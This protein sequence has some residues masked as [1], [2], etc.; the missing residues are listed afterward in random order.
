MERKHIA[1]FTPLATGHVYPALGVCSELVRRGHRVTYPTNDRFASR[2]RE[3]GAEAIEFKAP[4][5]RYP[6]K[7][8]QYPSSDE[9]SYWRAF[10]SMYGP[11]VIATAATTVV[12]LEGFYA[13]NP[14][15]LILYEWFSFAGRIISRQLGCPCV[16]LH[17]H[18]A[19]HD[20]VIRVD[21]VCTNPRPVFE[22]ARLLDTFMALFGFDGK[23]HLWHA[24]D[25]NIILI[26]RG[27]QYD[28]DTFDDRFKFVGASHNR[29]HRATSWKYDAEKQKPLLLVSEASTSTDGSF[30]RK[31]VE[32]FGDSQ[33]HVVYSK[34]ANSPEISS[35][36]LPRNFEVNKDA[37]NCEML[38]YSEVILCQGGMGTTLE[39]LSYGVPVVAVP[40]SPFNS[41][42]AYRMVELG[43]GVQVPEL[44]PTPRALKEAVDTA[45]LDEAL[46]TR[47]RRMQHSLKS[48]PGAE[49]AATAIEE[50]LA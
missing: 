36:Q 48:S 22:F 2:I 33:Y 20:T 11:M 10:A 32:G 16:Q 7:V 43:L 49:L 5:I 41:E 38:P 24:E 15:D 31:C 26:P 28:S 21:G 40:S 47:V 18:F 44:D 4:V 30:L 19:H 45:C 35:T 25:R 27:F 23:D 9:S 37:Y 29:T 13:T 14:P 3:A 1:V 34:G 50:V 12:E 17:A 6:E 42:V 46:R 39:S 8:F